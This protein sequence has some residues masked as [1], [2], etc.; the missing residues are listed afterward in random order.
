M[1][2]RGL[3]K[4][5]RLSWRRPAAAI[6]AALALGCLL[7][8]CGSDD[9]VDKSQVVLKVRPEGAPERL[10]LG[11]IY[12]QAL[13]LAGYDVKKAPSATFGSTIAFDELQAGKLAGYP[14]YMST[15]LFYKFGVEIA[16]IPTKAKPAYKQAKKNLEKEGL[17]AFPPTPYGI[18]NAVGMLRKTA[19]ERR[20]KTIS[21]LKGQAEEMTLKGPTYCHVSVECL[22]GIEVHY[23]TAFE[24][25][26]YERAATPELTWWRAEPEY[27]YQ[28]L[29]KGVSD[30]SILFNTDGRLATEGKKFVILEDDKD[31]FP[32]SNFVWVT[33]PEVVDE[34][35]PEYE[36]AIVAAQKGLTLKVMQE[37]NAELERG[38]TP[39]AV[40]A[41]YLKSIRYTG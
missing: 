16:D 10:L 27:R 28:V 8:A 9:P 23:D 15:T 4:G 31:I 37:L 20:L 26:S 11:Q 25:I 34:A 2:E 12:A 32:A 40:A 3:T 18:A 24:G 19:E 1:Q 38:K 14:E 6:L 33:S 30:A 17:T 36:K 22:G 5:G 13:R 29:E 7:S 35:G 39:A 41:G 21:D